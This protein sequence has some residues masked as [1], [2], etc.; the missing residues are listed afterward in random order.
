[1]R[2]RFEWH[3][4]GI[5]TIVWQKFAQLDQGTNDAQMGWDISKIFFTN[6]QLQGDTSGHYKH[7]LYALIGEQRSS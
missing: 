3:Q 1:M 6:F 2:G 7:A 5:W 4:S